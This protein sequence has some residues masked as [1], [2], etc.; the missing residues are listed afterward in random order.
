MAI[1]LYKYKS[2]ENFGHVADIIVNK[3]FYV[4]PYRKFNDA[5]EG[6]YKIGPHR[7]EPLVEYKDKCTEKEVE[8]KLRRLRVCCFCYRGDNSILWAHCADAFKGICIRFEMVPQS[9]SAEHTFTC[10]PGVTFHPVQY[11]GIAKKDKSSSYHP[12]TSQAILLRKMPE[13]S[14]ENE[15]RIISEEEYIPLG[16]E[17]RITGILLG[18]RIKPK[19]KSAWRAIFERLIDSRKI[20]VLETTINDAGKVEWDLNRAKVAGRIRGPV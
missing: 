13:W 10:R 4:T 9:G 5:I 3:R 11:D 18:P 6:K 15:C 8:E 12:S 20:K 16:N 19:M 2:L 17:I 7:R 14:V 1:T